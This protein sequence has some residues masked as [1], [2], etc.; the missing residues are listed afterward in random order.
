MFFAFNKYLLFISLIIYT[1]FMLVDVVPDLR[2]QKDTICLIFLGI[3][4]MAS[5]FN[6]FFR[7]SVKNNNDE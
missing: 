6:L 2:V 5:F 3:A 4:I 7:P 1:F